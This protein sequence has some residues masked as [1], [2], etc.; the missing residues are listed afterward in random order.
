MSTIAIRESGMDFMVD[1]DYLFRIEGNGYV[2]SIQG[3]KSCEYVEW[4][5]G[6]LVFLEAK[7][8]FP[9][10]ANSKESFA[11]FIGE[12][13]SKFEKSFQLFVSV[14]TGRLQNK[15]QLQLA[16]SG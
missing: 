5:N 3:L 2:K 4:S 6:N 14:L 7:T 1:E 15:P 11:D 13:T 12:I 9:H 16:F 8:S 10:P